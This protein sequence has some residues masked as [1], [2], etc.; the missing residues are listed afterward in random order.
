MVR[1][2]VQT[3]CCCWFKRFNAFYDV[4]YGST[5]NF[6]WLD[7]RGIL[8]ED[9]QVVPDNDYYQRLAYS[10]KSPVKY[11][12]LI[13]PVNRLAHISGTKNFADFEVKSC[14]CCCY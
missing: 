7:N 3:K 9:T 8:N 5:I 14:C 12:D 10:I 1:S 13:G 4:G 2:L 6:G 11:E